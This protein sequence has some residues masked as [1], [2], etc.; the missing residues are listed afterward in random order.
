MTLKVTISFVL[1]QSLIFY[2]IFRHGDTTRSGG[3]VVTLAVGYTMPSTS[4]F[5]LLPTSQSAD[6]QISPSILENLRGLIGM[7]GIVIVVSS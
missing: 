7:N 2:F 4:D 6:F 1:F 5:A 3:R